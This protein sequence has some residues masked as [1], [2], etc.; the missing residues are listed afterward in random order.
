MLNGPAP[1]WPGERQRESEMARTS[2][3]K[4]HVDALVV[5]SGPVGATVARRLVEAGRKVLMVEAGPKL[6]ERPGAHLKNAIKFQRDI[7]LFSNIIRGHLHLVSVPPNPKPEITLD[8]GSFQFDQE[9]FKGF[10]LNNQNPDQDP[11]DNLD[12]AAVTYG[13][14]GM[15][16]HWTCATPRQHPSERHTLYSDEEWEKLYAESER[17]INTRTDAFEHAIRHQIVRTALRNEYPEL[18]GPDQVQNLPLAVERRQDNSQFVHWSGT[19]TVLGPLADGE[20]AEPFELRPEH[21]CRRL[22]ASSDGSRIEAAEVQN[23][24]RWETVRVEADQFFVAA[25]AIG[26]PQLLWAS[27]IRPEPLGR[28]LTEQPCPSAR[29]CSATSLSKGSKRMPGSPSGCESTRSAPARS[30]ADTDG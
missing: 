20:H 8:P 30:G 9:R 7:D 26:T 18:E 10:V 25:N 2:D 13:V 11:R 22:I 29:S 5:G 1:A 23:T 14:G 24:A 16:T 21:L 19:D 28:Y 17:L 12:A 27:G 3:E 6:S 4:V 15:A